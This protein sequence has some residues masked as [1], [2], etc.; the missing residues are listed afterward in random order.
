MTSPAAPVVA[1]VGGGQLA[2]MMAP[3]A[4]ELGVHLRVLVEDPA[5]SAAQVVVDAPVGGAADESAIRDL[6]TP[7]DG[8][9]AADVL[10]FEHEHV[11]N[12]LLADLAEH[13]TPVRPGPHALV[14]AQDKIVM[15]RRLT[16][17]GAPC[18]RWAALPTD[19][20]AA[21]DALAAFLADAPDGAA[22]VK[23]A[24]GGYDGKGV[25]VVTAADAVDDW[26]DAHV[27]GGPELLVEAKVPFTRELAVLVARRPSG[28]V[29]TW[30]VVESVQRDGV[31]AEVIAPAPDLDDDLAAAARDV[32]VRI[33]DG[34]DVTG[35][36]AVEMFEAP[37]PDGTTQVLVNELAMRPHNSGH[38]TIDGAV[39]SQFEQHLRAVLDLPLGS[40]EAV[41][42][43]TVMANVLGSTLDRLT[44]ALPA[45]GEQFPDARVNL[46]GKGI[47]AGRKLGHV[48]VS[49]TD[50][51]EVRRRA[52][53]AAALLRGETPQ[54]LED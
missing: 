9:P 12:T 14:Q 8:R 27:A 17:L 19:P 29:R 33:A 50:L 37:G 3:A 41:A 47:R 34:L 36:L 7:A 51:T 42:T 24:R 54:N 4:A 46:Y 11:P 20:A 16:E 44:D 32:A 18:P 10:T 38:W 5:T 52:L 43:W 6:V 39:T 40:T 13:G 15:R 30:P 35:V 48:N 53:A 25:R 45:V 1:V 28:E 21:R 31:C 23:T 22:V 49:G 2:R 26:L